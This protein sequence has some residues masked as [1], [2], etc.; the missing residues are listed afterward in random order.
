MGQEYTDLTEQLERCQRLAKF[1]TDEP[2]RQA[3]EEL[4]REYEAKLGRRGAGF[5]LQDRH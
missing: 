4:A 2:M 3:L 1:V 5:M